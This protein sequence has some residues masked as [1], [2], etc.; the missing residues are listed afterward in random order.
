MM[1]KKK[2]EIYV[3]IP[4]CAKK[5]AY[6]DFLSF[7]GNMR[8][9]R[10]YTDKLLEEI[11]IQSSFVREYQVDTIFLGGGTPS[12]LDVTDITAIMGTLKEHYDIA[13]DAEITIE[14]NPGT[15]KM[16][17]LVAYREA[18]INRVSMGLQSADDTE[19]RYLGRI[20]TYD[21]FLKSFQRVRMAG[22]T[23]VNVDLISA[24]PGQ[25]PES[26]R[27]TLKKTAML[28][29][30]HISAYSLIVEEGTPF[31]DR[32]GGHVEM[33]SYEMSP[34]ERRRLMA[35]PDLPDEDTEREMYYM[36]RNCL[37]EQ[38]YERY[39]ISNYARPGFECRHNV[40]Y[41]T[42]T[43]YLGLGL[44]ASSYLEGCRFHNTSDFQSY[45]SA[46]F[47]DE[48]EFCQALRQDM[49]QLSVKSK[50]EEFM[51]LGLRLTRGVSV[52]GFI[53][54]FGQSIRNVY[55]GVIDKLEREGLLEHKNG[56]YHLTERGLDL[57]NYAMSLFLLD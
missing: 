31:Y 5:C 13:P 29:P 2:L 7:P 34:E 24:I 46:H 36:T 14:V 48:A 28:K 37:A 47:D 38:G 25:T 57:S 56:Y 50:M 39:E 55:G 3:H 54:R 30:E 18:G 26:W 35:L 20:H 17:G 1:N 9:R 42:G 16:E 51:F 19:L 43:G 27:N 44:G 12:V 52:E 4:F 23:N 22:F 21:E 10:E 11:R 8:M 53:T 40:G 6:C 49:E 45:V 41:W 32:Y 15:V 33:E